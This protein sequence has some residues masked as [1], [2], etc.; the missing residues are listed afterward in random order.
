VK[1]KEIEDSTKSAKTIFIYFFI[2]LVL[3]LLR[4]PFDKLF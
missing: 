4:T 3:I 1:A 2:A